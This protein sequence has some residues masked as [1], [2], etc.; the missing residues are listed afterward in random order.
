MNAEQIAR[1]LGGAY[2]REGTSWRTECPCHS[3]TADNS[4]ALWDDPAKGHVIVQCFTGCDFRDV[5]D[6]LRARG[7]WKDQKHWQ[8]DRTRRPNRHPPARPAKPPLPGPSYLPA[9]DWGSLAT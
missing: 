6:E 5:I 8:R 9:A 2:H 3:G 7:L 1:G 4:L